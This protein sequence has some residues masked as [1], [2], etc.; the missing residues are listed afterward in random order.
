M[1]KATALAAVLS[2]CIPTAGFAGEVAGV[3]LPDTITVDGKTL[4]LN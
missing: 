3:T 2:L 4:K 1:R